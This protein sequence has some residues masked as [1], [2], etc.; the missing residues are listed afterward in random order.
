MTDLSYTTSGR[1]QPG[2]VAAYAQVYLDHVVGDDAVAVLSAVARDTLALLSPLRDDA[3]AGVRYAPDKWT[4]K[5]IVG[6]LVD[7]ERIMSYRA[8]CIAR[9]ERLQLL[10]FDEKVYAA[11]AGAELR[12]MA[13]L[14]AEYRMV[15]DASLALFRS[16]TSEAWL[17]LGI[18]NGH[19]VSARGVAFHIAGHEL[20][21]V[22]MIRHQYLPLV[23]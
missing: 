21:H 11:N 9:G 13:G 8:L 7:D 23:K 14:L 5:D 19:V 3:I 16:F 4:I 12:P 15:R 18:A 22:R 1:P 17:R 10:G 6:H 2:E 20:H